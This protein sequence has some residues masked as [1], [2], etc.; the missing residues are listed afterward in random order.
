VQLPIWLKHI[1]LQPF[2]TLEGSGCLY[3]MTWCCSTWYNN[4]L[5]VT[6]Y[7]SHCTVSLHFRWYIAYSTIQV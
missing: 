4:V 7:Y 1:E 2:G 6:V 5:Y 3:N